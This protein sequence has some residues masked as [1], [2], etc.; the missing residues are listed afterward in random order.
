VLGDLIASEVIP[1]IT[2]TELFRQASGSQIVLAAHA[3]NRGEVPEIEN[4]PNHDLFFVRVVEDEK[5]VDAIKRLLLE[6]IPPRFGLDPI[7]D[8]QVISPMYAGPAGVVNLNV[9]L[10]AFLNPATGTKPELRRGD[11]LFRVGD[12]VMQIRNNYEKEVFNGDVG[13]VFE[14]NADEQRLVVSYP[15][16]GQAVEIE[17]AAGDL[18]ELVL[19]YAISVHKAQGSEFPGIIMPLVT[20]HYMMLRRNLLYTAISRAQHLCVLIGSTRALTTAVRDSHRPKRNTEL[21]RR[22]RHAETSEQ[23]E[24][25]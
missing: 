24:L 21:A 23:L 18:D 11:H 9:E 19:A 22:V 8:V 5:V 4:A 6:R 10:Q 20:R 13:K 16:P 25:V 14:V 1:T 3:V 15:S 17:Y 7:D 12:K 2:L